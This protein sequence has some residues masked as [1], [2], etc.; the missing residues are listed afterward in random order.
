MSNAMDTQY[1]MCNSKK[2]R[3]WNSN[4]VRAVFTH[5]IF[6]MEQ[7][8]HISQR[9]L[10]SLKSLGGSMCLLATSIRTRDDSLER[11][12]QLVHKCNWEV[13]CALDMAM[14]CRHVRNNMY[15]LLD[16]NDA[17]AVRMAVAVTKAIDDEVRARQYLIVGQY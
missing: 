5:F 6:T 2:E 1:N 16:G 7:H 14:V 15:M 11:Y 17:V 4:I 9:R 13:D 12:I 3:S 10:A 8:S